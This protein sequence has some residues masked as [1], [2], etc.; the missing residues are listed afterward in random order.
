MDTFNQ[1][2]TPLQQQ[3]LSSAGFENLYSLIT[4][5]PFDL[6]KI[7][8]L[9]NTF[10]LPQEGVLYLYSGKLTNITHRKGGKYFLILD[11]EGKFS[12]RCYLFSVAKYTLKA[13]QIGQDYQ[14]LVVYRGGF[15]NLEKFANQNAVKQSK[16]FVL[17]QAAEQEYLLPKY[18]KIGELRNGDFQALHRRLASNDYLLNLTGLVPINSFLPQFINLES[19]HKPTSIQSYE[20]T[21][22]QWVSFKVFLR[23]SLLKYMDRASSQ[24]VSWS[25][26][27][28][29]DFL[30][31][32]STKLPFKLSDTQKTVV[33]DILQEITEI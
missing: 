4:Y 32:I 15:W 19:I 28:D 2:F 20:Q 3:K 1:R 10:N 12:L 6:A 17:G 30:K 22:H 9:Q 13:L 21:L 31:R 8:P 14:I 18:T 23:L 5:L 27:L 26:K 24:S 7:R 16:N 25:G 11:F 29:L 33:W